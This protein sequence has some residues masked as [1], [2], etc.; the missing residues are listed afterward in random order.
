MH[1]LAID[2]NILTMPARNGL[3]VHDPDFDVVIIGA[4]LAGINAAYRLQKHTQLTYS[5]LEARSA[6]GG[7]WDLFHYPGVR[8]DSDMYTYGFPWYPWMGKSSFGTGRAISQYLQ[9]AAVDFGIERHIQY[10]RKV[11]LASWSSARQ[12]WRLRLQPGEDGE[13]STFPWIWARFVVFSTGYYDYS[14]PLQSEIPGLQ[15][16]RGAVVH[17]QFWPSFLDYK[18]K[19]VVVIGSGATA[20]TLV[21]E[22]AKKASHVYMLQ[23]SP[24]YVLSRPGLDSVERACRNCLPQRTAYSL[25]RWKNILMQTVVFEACHAFPGAAKTWLERETEKQLPPWVSQNPAFNPAYKPWDQ[26]LCVTADGELFSALRNGSTEIVTDRIRDM[27]ADSIILDSGLSIANVDMIVTATGLKV[28]LVGGIVLV[29]DR[30][31]VTLSNRFLWN[32]VLLQDVPNATFLVGST[33]GSWTLRVD[34]KMRLVTRVLNEMSRQQA[35]AVTPC[36]ADN[37]DMPAS[38]LLDLSSTYLELVKKDLPKAGN[39]RP[40][41]PESNYYR[42]YIQAR[43]GRVSHGLKYTRCQDVQSDDL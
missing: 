20:V 26:R 37:S 9:A 33:H 40:W 32:G 10:G 8:S 16:F 21:P 38:S 4:G 2:I 30:H 22:L 18:D 14:K 36:L 43:L 28:Q 24:S 29:V 42:E 41:T 7:T 12:L 6:L 34:N 23:R 1:C 11:V 27:T 31:P 5:I 19:T 3:S 13:E 35:T 25:S 17:P 39:R 15:N